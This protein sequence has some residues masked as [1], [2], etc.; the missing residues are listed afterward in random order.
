MLRRRIGIGIAEAGSE[1]EDRMWR[2]V[3]DRRGR[4]EAAEEAAGQA[5]G[6]GF[7]GGDRGMWNKLEGWGYSL[8]GCKVRGVRA[9][10]RLELQVPPLSKLMSGY[11]LQ[12]WGTVPFGGGR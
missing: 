3:E 2:Q 9:S 11:S 12:V 8:M 7:L 6:S 4:G 5:G 1:A 10:S